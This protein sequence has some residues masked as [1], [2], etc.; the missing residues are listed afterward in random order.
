MVSL[1]TVHHYVLSAVWCSLML[2]KDQV[3]W[4]DQYLWL[5]CS[6]APMSGFIH[7]ARVSPQGV[8]SVQ[9]LVT[10]HNKMSQGAVGWSVTGPFI[11]TVFW[12]L[13]F[14]FRYVWSHSEL[15]FTLMYIIFYCIMIYFIQNCEIIILDACFTQELWQICRK[16]CGFEHSAATLLN[17][18]NYLELLF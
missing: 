2:T 16:T 9:F 6:S 12:P 11:Y 15:F 13:V 10:H 8:H 17:G 3:L 7:S 5:L 14:K 4:S 1:A 18:Q